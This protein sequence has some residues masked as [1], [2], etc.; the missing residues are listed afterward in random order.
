M[1]GLASFHFLFGSSS[2]PSPPLSSIPPATPPS[3]ELHYLRR[4]QFPPSH[5]YGY[6]CAS[7][8]IPLLSLV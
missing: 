6:H 8:L 7:C 3:F 5:H 4:P 2:S 1:S